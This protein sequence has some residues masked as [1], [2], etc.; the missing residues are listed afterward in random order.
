MAKNIDD[1]FV[2][3]IQFWIEFLFPDETNR[4][5]VW[6]KVFP[7]KTPLDKDVDFEFLARQFQISG[8]HIK[9]IALRSAFLASAES[10]K[11]SMRHIIFATKREFEKLG[12]PITKSDFTK[13]YYLFL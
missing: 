6:Q 5:E 8:G 9:N 10:E 4:L 13:Y 2:R 3:R 1:A 12:K 11:V 7:S